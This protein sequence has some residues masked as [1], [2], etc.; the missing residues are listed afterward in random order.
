V[1]AIRGELEDH[2]V[3]LH[4]MSSDARHDGQRGQ[5]LHLAKQS[6]RF[7]EKLSKEVI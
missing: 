3:V 2:A 4:D 6:K 1:N 5:S 7:E